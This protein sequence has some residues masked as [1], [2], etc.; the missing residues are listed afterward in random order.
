MLASSAVHSSFLRVK[1]NVAKLE[2]PP[3]VPHGPACLAKGRCLPCSFVGRT[4]SG[5]ARG[6]PA[7]SPG[8]RGGR[9]SLSQGQ[10]SSLSLI[11]M[12]VFQARCSFSLMPPSVYAD[13]T[14]HLHITLWER[15]LRDLAQ[16]W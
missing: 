7:V 3:G 8:G 13:I 6:R 12:G 1:V 11:K 14:S 16:N 15:G 9:L 4:I 5:G 2:T 10:A